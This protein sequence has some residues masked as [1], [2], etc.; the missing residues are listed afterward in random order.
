MSQE[1][2]DT[3]SR[4]AGTADAATAQEPRHTPG[5]WEI[6]REFVDGQDVH[7]RAPVVGNRGDYWWIAGMCAGMFLDET[8]ANARLISAA[9][10][11]YEA[12]KRARN[13]VVAFALDTLDAEQAKAQVAY[14]DAAIARAEGKS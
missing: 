9:P 4:N 8:E 5:P 7:I 12:L 3:A 1:Q 10:D 11:L 13:Q 2:E 14:I 6:H